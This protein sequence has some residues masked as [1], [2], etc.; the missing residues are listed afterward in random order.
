M[1]NN[2]LAAAELLLVLGLVGW[3]FYSQSAA[4]KRAAERKNQQ[5]DQDAQ[6][7]AAQTGADEETPR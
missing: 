7:G 6:A 1:A 4:S 5:R 2:S 3:M